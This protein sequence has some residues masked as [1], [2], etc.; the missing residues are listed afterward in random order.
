MLTPTKPQGEI[1]VILYT[2]VCFPFSVNMS[3]G[4]I[5]IIYIIHLTILITAINYIRLPVSVL[6]SSV[7]LILSYHQEVGLSRYIQ[8]LFVL[9]WCCLFIERLSTAVVIPTKAVL[10]YS[11]FSVTMILSS[12]IHHL[13][14]SP[15]HAPLSPPPRHPPR[16]SLSAHL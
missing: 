12:L 15:S 14:A 10:K 7:H 5:C 1:S 11:P 8:A 13:P 6:S 2:S 9:D 4:Y 16:A 3:K